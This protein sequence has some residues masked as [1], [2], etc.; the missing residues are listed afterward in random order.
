MAH[1]VEFRRALLPPDRKNAH[2][3][4]P[5]ER[6]VRCVAEAGFQWVASCSFAEVVPVLFSKKPH[7]GEDFLEYLVRCCPLKMLLEAQYL[8]KGRG[9]IPSSED[10]GERWLPA[11]ALAALIGQ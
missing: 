8:H 4:R 7:K 9:V 11:A 3:A 1:N 5:L 10:R 2:V 6:R